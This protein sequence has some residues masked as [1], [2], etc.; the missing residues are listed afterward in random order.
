MTTTFPLFEV[1]DN[2]PGA[3]TINCR[4]GMLSRFESLWS[5]FQ[6]LALWNNVGAT[7][8]VACVYDQPEYTARRRSTYSALY[9]DYLDGNRLCAITRLTS[10]HLQY[11]V[12]TD[13]LIC[14]ESNRAKA[15]S[16]LC[17]E[18]RYCRDC[19]HKG[20]HTPLFQVLGVRCCPVH[21]RPLETGCPRC[22]VA[23][24]YVIGVSHVRAYDCTCGERLWTIGRD[25]PLPTL[26]EHEEGQLGEYIKWKKRLEI[27]PSMPLWAS[28]FGLRAFVPDSFN[29]RLGCLR[30]LADTTLPQNLLSQDKA[31]CR[32]GVAWS[33]SGGKQSTHDAERAKALFNQIG[34]P[35]CVSARFSST[36]VW[37]HA[38]IRDL[39]R[40]HHSRCV[41]HGRGLGHTL[42]NE[43]LNEQMTLLPCAFL[44]SYARW[45]I[46]WEDK[47]YD[48]LRYAATGTEALTEYTRMMWQEHSAPYSELESVVE[49]VLVLT[50]IATYYELF[51]AR[52]Y[53]AERDV[54]GPVGK[55]NPYF[56]WIPT[57]P[58]W[59][60]RFVWWIRPILEELEDQMVFRCSWGQHEAI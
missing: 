54:V 15:E 23:I 5:I 26:T 31:E 32:A 12:G 19:L 14:A 6:K 13:Y 21:E 52:F 9:R 41:K 57:G 55:F 43:R 25:T 36:Y 18:L 1:S 10:W 17:E 47:R 46:F 27:K 44:S 33:A 49:R 30:E 37:V 60:N 22:R 28:A 35:T 16:S 56:A 51:R 58:A 2:A 40:R 4:P 39:L 3:A 11:S 38:R 48:E 7:E 34:D 20:F 59:R 45:R 24:R 8:L 50:M 53:P 42:E 29:S